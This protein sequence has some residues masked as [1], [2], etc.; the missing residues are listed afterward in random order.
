MKAKLIT[1]AVGLANRMKRL[2]MWTAFLA[3]F[4]L[5]A[6]VVI[7]WNFSLRHKLSLPPGAHPRILD[8]PATPSQIP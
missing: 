3:I 1:T 5:L 4:V 8:A 6:F 2:E 7:F